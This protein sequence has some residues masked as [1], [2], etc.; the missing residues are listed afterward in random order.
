MGWVFNNVK[1]MDI[2]TVRKEE[3]L[4]IDTESALLAIEV[5][6]IGGTS[7]DS[8]CNQITKNRS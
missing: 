1:L 2:E 4:Q 5:K 3:D 8:D 6:G 7:T